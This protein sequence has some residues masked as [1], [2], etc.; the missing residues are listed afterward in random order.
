MKR[1]LIITGAGALVVALALIGGTMAANN[2]QTAEA[3]QA[4]ISVNGLKGGI[5][6]GEND[7]AIF[8]EEDIAAT[9]GGDYEI[10]RYAVNAG[11][12]G[13]YASY[14]KVVIYKAWEDSKGEY[15]DIADSDVVED[16]VYVG[17]E[18]QVYEPGLEVG[19]T[20]N[21]WRVEYADEEEIV[22]F[23]TE[24][25][26]VG[27]ATA[28]FINGVTF[29]TNLDNQYCGATYNLE[30]EVTAVQANNGKDAFASTLGLYPTFD[31]D[32]TI[33]D[34]SEEKPVE[35]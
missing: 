29:T 16:T 14:F 34:L 9:P 17:E 31:S 4:E 11:E 3:A 10:E 21:G 35:E 1:N 24:P 12:K 15:I 27:E 13:D 33:I 2:A 28:P 19:T 5:G 32:G 6:I 26:P 18:K 22:L 20:F 23:Y 30:F 7:S 8:S 25:V